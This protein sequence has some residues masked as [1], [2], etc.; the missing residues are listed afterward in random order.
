[1]KRT[2]DQVERERN[3]SYGRYREEINDYDQLFEYIEP[4]QCDYCGYYFDED[5]IE[6]IDGENVCFPCKEK[7]LN[8]LEIM[9]DKV[10]IQ[11]I[12]KVFNNLNK[13]S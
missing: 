8:D 5:E 1:M 12:E 9:F 4:I 2:I 3:A 13:A 7:Y 6:K 10:E 11:E